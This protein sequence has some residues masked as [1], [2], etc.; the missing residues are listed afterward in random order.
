[1]LLGAL[2]DAGAD[3]GA[4]Q[5]AVDAVV[6][7]AVRLATADVRRA[8][9]RALKVTA[10]V[11]VDDPPHRT[12]REIRGLLD[13]A[14]LAEPVRRPV[15]ATFAR[16]AEAEAR[17]HGIPAEEVSFHEVGALDS[18]ADTVGVCAALDD[19]GVTACSAGPVAVGSGQ[20]R[21]RH[22][23]LP[24]PVPAV[25]QLAVG[26][27]VHAG[28]VGELATPTGMALVRT[29]ASVCE[30]LPDLTVYAVGVGAG[31][32]DF[33]GR[34]N[35][36]RV[37]IGSATR[38]TSTASDEQR[39]DDTTM[40]QLAANVDDLDPRLWPGVLAALLDGGAAD[41]W[42]TPILMKKGRPA[43]T[44]SVLCHPGRA[45]A[46]QDVIFAHTSTL[47]VRRATLARTA[48]TRTAVTVVVA[49]G[50]VAVKLGHTAG[51]I[52]QVMPEFADVAAVAHARGR[53]ERLVLAEALVAAAAAGLVVGAPL[54]A[55]PG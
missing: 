34:A 6:P 53:P 26:W 14:D 44:L 37:V 22:G 17:V 15:R 9:L 3:L 18:I 20:V 30:P 55:S 10:A 50:T 52:R 47:G 11:A 1:M 41:A 24:V 8:G 43:H 23:E 49:G 2:L 48:L 36:V 27:R 42:L 40:M 16:L 45:T 38:V 33:P 32:R 46:L 7:G 25:A 51:L 54:P 21:T 5:R 12:W 19:L 13:A 4:V 39:G 35:V 29:L 31:T 28:G